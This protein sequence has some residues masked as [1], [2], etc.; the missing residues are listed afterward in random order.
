[1]TL[2]QVNILNN[3]STGLYATGNALSPV[4]VLSS[5]IQG[6][7]EGGIY[8]VNSGRVNLSNSA[9]LNNTNGG[10][11]GG[12]AVVSAITQPLSIVNSTISGNKTNGNGGGLYNSFATTSIN[13]VTIANN[14]ADNEA[15]GI[16]DGGGVFNTA[17]G[18]I[19]LKNSI[20]AGNLDNSAATKHPDCS[21]PLTSQGYNLIQTTTG[22]TVSPT[23]NRLGQNPALGVL[24][25]SPAYHPIAN[26]S[27]AF[28]AGNPAT[29]G[30]GGDACAATDQRGVSRLQN[31]RCDMG[32]FELAIPILTISKTAP[33]TATTSQQ[34]TYTL[35]AANI[36]GE[37]A[38][39]VTVT[40][41]LPSGAT[42]VQALNG[43]T[44][45]GNQVVWSVGNLPAQTSMPL[46]F[47][48][49]AKQTVVNKNY[50]VT[51][52]GGLTASGLPVTTTVQTSNG[53]PINALIYLPVVIK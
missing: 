28:N 46:R 36:G 34:I 29:P 51:G 31:G 47:V 38:T 50:S 4:S 9:I 35:T 52:S 18:A 25:G 10:D 43:G 5:T 22:C 39:G 27:P 8:I 41:T 6:N 13:N 45:N 23:N 32:A 42:F 33:V 21:G 15:N 40:D 17:G 30:S 48:V 11:G 49:T 53:T 24:T 19:N 3:S 2:N 14:T 12:I 1:V 7:S 26:T 44:L 16:G 20:I 37:A